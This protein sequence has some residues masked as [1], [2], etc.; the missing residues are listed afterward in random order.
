M[1][2]SI[3]VDKIILMVVSV[4]FCLTMM[5]GFLVWA[6]GGTFGQRCAKVYPNDPLKSEQ[7]VFDLNLGKRL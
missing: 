5:V 6:L 7:C 4:I 2:G 1:N 3:T